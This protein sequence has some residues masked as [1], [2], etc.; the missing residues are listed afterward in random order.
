MYSYIEILFKGERK[1]IYHNPMQF[2][3]K[4]GDYAVVEADKGED[5]GVI[6]QLGAMVDRKKGDGE[7]KKILRKPTSD[8]L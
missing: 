5:L 8:E 4:V 1:D 2:P 6:H 3:F 7:R